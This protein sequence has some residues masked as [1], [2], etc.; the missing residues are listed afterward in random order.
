MCT[1]MRTGYAPTD[2]IER[3]QGGRGEEMRGE[4][5]VRE[6]LRG[7]QVGRVEKGAGLGFGH[8]LPKGEPGPFYAAWTAQKV[9]A[10]ADRRGAAVPG[11]PT[12]PGA[13][14]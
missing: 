2:T 11:P 4:S 5:R 12:Q 1:G 10:A 9:M 6:A 14:R 3:A 8:L 7:V 13:G